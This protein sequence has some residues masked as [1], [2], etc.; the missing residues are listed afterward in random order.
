MESI[1]DC[2]VE[3]TQYGGINISNH[4]SV[5]IIAV[6]FINYNCQNNVVFEVCTFDSD[7][8]GILKL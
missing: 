8:N 7:F 6:Q 2:N 1:R 5:D 3:K 4:C